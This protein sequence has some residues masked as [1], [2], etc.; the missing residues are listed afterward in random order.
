MQY[1]WHRNICFSIRVWEG[2]GGYGAGFSAEFAGGFDFAQG[3]I[4]ALHGFCD[5]HEPIEEKVA[6]DGTREIIEDVAELAASFG[7]ISLREK[8]VG[9]ASVGEDTNIVAL[10]RG[11]VIEDVGKHRFDEAHGPDMTRIIGLWPEPAS[12]VEDCAQ[13]GLHRVF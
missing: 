1:L 6:G 11:L 9:G 4:G 7:G 2:G 10:A 8:L 5:G 13:S 3:A 12:A